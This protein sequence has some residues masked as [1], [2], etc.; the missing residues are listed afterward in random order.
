MAVNLKSLLYLLIMSNN[1]KPTQLPRVGYTYQDYMC[2][3][4]LIDWFH[5]PN[6]YQ[7]ASIEGTN[8]E[9]EFKG[10][11]DIILLNKNGS[12]ELFQ[13]KFT[14]DTKRN[15][16]TLNFDW[17]LKKTKNGTSLLQKWA[18]DVTKYNIKNRLS[19]A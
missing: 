2:I 5:N 12:Y 15:D 18:Q 3:Q 4:L 10:L 14:I 17:L 9:K 11:D 1:I 6:K 19:I 8:T 16:L 13:V 7:W